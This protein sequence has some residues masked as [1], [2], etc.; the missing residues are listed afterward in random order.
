MNPIH[1]SLRPLLVKV[2]HPYSLTDL[3]V[4]TRFARDRRTVARWGNHDAQSRTPSIRSD[5]ESVLTVPRHPRILAASGYLRT[6]AHHAPA[7]SQSTRGINLSRD[8]LL[9]Q[10]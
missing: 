1:N 4:N 6:H 5:G 7:C 10:G 8:R 9:L 2:Y 3:V